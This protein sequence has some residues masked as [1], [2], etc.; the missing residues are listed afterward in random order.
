M[1]SILI[2]MEDESVQQTAIVRAP[3]A[4]EI[5][6]RSP[7]R[8]ASTALLQGERQIVIEHAGRD[9]CLRLTAQGK[10]ILTA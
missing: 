10:L 7:R 3:V 4:A 6:S 8:F 2:C 1:G 9:Y 5:S